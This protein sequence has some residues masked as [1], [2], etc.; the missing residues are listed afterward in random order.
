MVAALAAILI[1]RLTTQVGPMTAGL[2][3]VES[4]FITGLVLTFRASLRERAL[5]LDAANVRIGELNTSE[6][7]GRTVDAALPAVGGNRG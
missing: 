5:T 6:R 2:F 7:H 1:A 4:L 3:F